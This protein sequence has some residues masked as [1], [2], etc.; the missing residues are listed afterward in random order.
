MVAGTFDKLVK[1]LAGEEKPG[2]HNEDKQGL[3]LGFPLSQAL[4]IK[5]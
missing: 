2:K 5:G 4:P 3:S 1:Q